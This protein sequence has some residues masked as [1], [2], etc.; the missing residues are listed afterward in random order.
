M[1]QPLDRPRRQRRRQPWLGIA[2]ALCLFA[3]AAPV[4]G[5]EPIPGGKLLIE[6]DYSTVVLRERGRI[7]LLSF[8][9]DSGEEAVQS[10]IDLARPQHLLIG[11]TRSMFAS[12]LFVPEPKKVLIVGLGAGSMVRFLEY[13]E[14]Q[15]E[16]VA[17]DIDPK[18]LEIAEQYFG[19]KPGKRIRLVAADGVEFIARKRE[20]FDVIY[21]D[22]FL[23]PS[24]TTDATG[25]P[26]AMKTRDFYRDLQ[27]GLNP[28]GVVVFN[29][30]PHEQSA[31]D[32]E[33][34]RRSFPGVHAFRVPERKIKILVATRSA[35]PADPEKLRAI[36]R[37]VDA[38]LPGSFSVEALVGDLLP[39]R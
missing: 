7:R 13:H 16:I 5:L 10:V 3:E 30:N 32:I 8:M 21:M 36:G 17:I 28:G 31:E 11:Y 4:A 14:P 23:K 39:E 15:V 18:M 35:A 19:T 34:I 29:V 22:A 1:M 27:A 12:Y 6:T 25:L 38:R 20:R 37:Q 2:V 33:A 9:R 26:L 24:A